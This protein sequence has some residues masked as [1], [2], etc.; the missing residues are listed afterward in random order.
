MGWQE[1]GAAMAQ[2]QYRPTGVED[3]LFH[4]DVIHAEVVKE[5]T[6]NPGSSRVAKLMLVDS[7]GSIVAYHKPL[8]GIDRA[9]AAH[10]GHDPMS[11]LVNEAVAWMLAKVLGSPYRDLVPD[12]V[13]RSIWPSAGTSAGVVNGYGCLTVQVPGNANQAQPLSDPNECD[14]AAFFDALIGQQDRH[15]T[16]YRWQP[17]Q[18]GLLDNA[19]SFAAPGGG[20]LAWASEFV[21]ARHEGGRAALDRQE[22]R[23]LG[24]LRESA[25]L[26]TWVGLMLRTD[27]AAALRDRVDRMIASEELLGTLEF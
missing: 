19:Y 16:N 27:Q 9:Q 5:K 2:Q 3:R 8:D 23:L 11:V 4:A 24:D 1:I 21:Q 6:A 13:I 18:L 17:E 15:R 10:Y 26:W 14:P 22:L 7:F 20:Y 25:S 12:M